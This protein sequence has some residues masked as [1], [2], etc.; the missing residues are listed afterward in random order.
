MHTAFSIQ[1]ASSVLE[2]RLRVIVFDK[3]AILSSEGALHCTNTLCFDEV[4]LYGAILGL[5]KS[6]PISSTLL[7]VV[8]RVHRSEK[9]QVACPF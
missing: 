6:H 4:I 3:I 5:S 8:H 1:I 7:I 9:T 2:E